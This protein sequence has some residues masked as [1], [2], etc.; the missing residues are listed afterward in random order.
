[1]AEILDLLNMGRTRS[2]VNPEVRI[3]YKLAL[4]SFKRGSQYRCCYAGIE[5]F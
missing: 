2:T 5:L 3:V 4:T 1:M